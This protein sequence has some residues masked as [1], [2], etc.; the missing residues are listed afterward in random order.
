MDSCCREGVHFLMGQGFEELVALRQRHP[1]LALCVN[2]VKARS[3]YQLDY[4]I[5]I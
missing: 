2:I 4:S 1:P 5:Q 3:V